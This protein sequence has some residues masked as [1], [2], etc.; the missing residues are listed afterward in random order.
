M[1]P[2]WLCQGH[3]SFLFLRP[4]AGEGWCG[5]QGDHRLPVVFLGAWLTVNR[6]GLLVTAN[7]LFPGSA[8]RG[9][10]PLP[11]CVG[12]A[13]WVQHAI[14][15]PLLKLVLPGTWLRSEVCSYSG[16]QDGPV[17]LTVKA[18]CVF[19]QPLPSIAYQKNKQQE[20]RVVAVYSSGQEILRP[21]ALRQQ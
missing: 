5:G 9:T 4:W 11:V 18:H 10:A 2:A 15:E 12:C 8:D 7:W 1:N 17:R 21:P 20:I 3:V 16:G 6:S 13:R 14:E 19:I